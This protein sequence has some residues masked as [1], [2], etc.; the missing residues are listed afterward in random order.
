MGGNGVATWRRREI[1]AKEGS[2]GET[3][4]QFVGSIWE[5][6]RGFVGRF[7]GIIEMKFRLN[8]EEGKKNPDQR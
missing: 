5:A 6:W 8:K 2:F 4:D 1:G 3:P 7:P